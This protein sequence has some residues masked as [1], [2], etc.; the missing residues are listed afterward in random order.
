MALY[1]NAGRFTSKPY[2]AS[3]QYIKR[4]SNYCAGCHYRPE[5]KTGP[6]ACPVT[7][8]YW[9]FL[10]KR[11]PLLTREHYSAGAINSPRHKLA[12]LLVVPD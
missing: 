7:T 3:G 11:R 5:V 8:L 2:I 9:H 10:D 12:S 1:A 6:R 4:M